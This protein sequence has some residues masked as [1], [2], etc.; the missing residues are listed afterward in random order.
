MIARAIRKTDQQQ[1]AP[2]ILLI[3]IHEFA[4]HAEKKAAVAKI[5][6]VP[7]FLLLLSSGRVLSHGREIK[8]TGRLL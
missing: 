4:C 2:L 1:F 6:S 3:C 8:Y 7:E 5:I